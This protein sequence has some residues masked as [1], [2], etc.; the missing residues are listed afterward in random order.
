M[1]R[2][3]ATIITFNE[4]QNIRRCIE[5]LIKVADEI[6]VVD[7]YSTD[8]TAAICS[9]LGV[10]FISNPFKGYI[11]QKNYAL[12]QTTHEWVISLDADEA[13]SPEL[14]K[15][16]I[17]LM[18]N[19][20]CDQYSMNRLT[21]YCGQW[22]RHCGWYPDPKIRLF[23]KRV[24][25]WD[26]VNPHDTIVSVG[27]IKKAHISGD[28]LHYSYNSVRAHITQAENFASITADAMFN[29]GIKT[30]QRNVITKPFIRFLRDY[31]FRMGLLDG[32]NGFLICF[33]S[34]YAS[35]MK[36][37]LLWEKQRSSGSSH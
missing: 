27:K 17:K 11:E 29:R 7:S 14:A 21:Q 25:K 16:I 13:L 22:I 31:F 32:Y 10:R 9:E 23:N 37:A 5:S 3:S 4:E 1:H 24:S 35:F 12:A 28:I 18:P 20:T 8:S 36:H 33:I 30:N 15:Q 6:V 34:A 19:P 2:L 26:G